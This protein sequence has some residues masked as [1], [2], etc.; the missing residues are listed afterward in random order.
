MQGPERKQGSW[1]SPDHRER[2]SE[3]CKQR[4]VA[5]TDTEPGGNTRGQPELGLGLG[6]GLGMWRLTSL[7]SEGDDW[8]KA[9]A[10]T[11]PAGPPPPARGRTSQFLKG[12]HTLPHWGP[13]GSQPLG[14]RRHICSWAFGQLCRSAGGK[15]HISILV[16]PVLTTRR[17]PYK[18]HYC[19][20]VAL[21]ASCCGEA[22]KKP[23]PTVGS[24]LMTLPTRDTKTRHPWP[25]RLRM[26]HGT[27]CW[28]SREK[29]LIYL[30]SPILN[31]STLT[32]A[33]GTGLIGA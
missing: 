20:N 27:W 25:L 1:I 32:S 17:E 10:P 15:D 16:C 23:I 5:T 14:R 22:G 2:D 6:C 33:T 30:L 19:I 11:D 3:K 21:N 31:Q 8:H 29:L 12:F 4:Q 26:E 24:N 18:Y 13:W 28:L 7:P 9:S